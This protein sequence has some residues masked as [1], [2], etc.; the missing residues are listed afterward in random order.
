MIDFTEWL[1]GEMEDPEFR[2][3]YDKLEPEFQLVRALIDGRH[4][5][6]MTQQQLAEK[7]VVHQINIS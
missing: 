5:N 1:S 2:K 6:G 3:E 7:S 4:E